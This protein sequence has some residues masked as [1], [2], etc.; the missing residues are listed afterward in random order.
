MAA[1]FYL[2]VLKFV[3]YAHAHFQD[4]TNH[5]TQNIILRVEKY[6]AKTSLDSTMAS[7]NAHY[8]QD[9]QVKNS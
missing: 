2:G 6:Y 1:F 7:T 9:R 8:S 5:E 4:C 3:F